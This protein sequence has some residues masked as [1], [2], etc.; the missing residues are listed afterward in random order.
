MKPTSTDPEMSTVLPDPVGPQA[1]GHPKGLYYLFF[2]ELWERFSFY[3]MRALLTLYMVEQVF[4][5]LAN[6]DTVSAIVYSSY[7]SLVYASPII[8][9][10][11]A[12]QL[13]GS[14]QSILLGGILMAIGHFVLAIENNTAFFLALAF[15]IVGNGFFKPNISTF[16]GAL[17]PDGDP[18]KDSGFTIFH[19]GINIGAFASPLLCGWLGATYGWHWGFGLAG[20]GM[21]VGVFFFW[22]GIQKGVFMEEGLPPHP[23]KLHEKVAGISRQHWI[24]I[25]SVAAVPVIAFL[26]SSYEFIANGSTIL[27]KVT[28]VN[29]IFYGLSIFILGY[30]SY[31]IYQLP[32]VARKKMIVAVLLT[33]FMTLFWG[34]HELSG[35]IITLFSARNV[36]LWLMN[37]AQTNA[38]N[39]L[40][41]ILLAVPISSLWVVL[42]RK[43][44]NPRTPYKFA[45]GLALLG[46]GYYLLFLSQNFASPEGTVPFIF[47]IL[48][49]LFMSLGELFTYPVGLSKITD[50]S[51]KTIVA[52][53][54]GV[55]FLSSA[56]AFQIV[57]FVGQRLAIDEIVAEEGGAVTAL[58]TLR[59]YTEGFES[60]AYV[61]L[62]GA[63]LV[64]L[65][66]PLLT[67]WMGNVH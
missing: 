23:E 63:L 58:D 16:V 29:V 20:V 31:V 12:D 45:A 38:L 50:L 56:Y 18:R 3:G 55:W 67:R 44:I 61:A 9:G 1:F 11:I 2:A 53:M 42:A 36:D 49:Y 34:F 52:F 57:G 27:G 8:G 64:V 40:F 19:M 66:S 41:I 21:L 33:V 65:L 7:G 62:G 51:P 17:Y 47:L 25:L 22:R 13:N 48:L 37:A 15:I 24:T 30:L 43:G 10:R 32:P 46:L 26:L 39:P 6:R 35:N 4:E 28:I 14:R 5:S 59:V 60:I 54:M